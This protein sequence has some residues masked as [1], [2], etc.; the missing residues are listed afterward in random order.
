M[1]VD[2]KNW[3]LEVTSKSCKLG[4]Q[5][6]I[7]V[8]STM[9]MLKKTIPKRECKI[10]KKCVFGTRSK[11]KHIDMELTNDSRSNEG[12]HHNFATN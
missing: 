1:F 7:D 3:C 11:Q 2:S 8:E 12:I 9:A 5:R 10:I 6:I 4:T